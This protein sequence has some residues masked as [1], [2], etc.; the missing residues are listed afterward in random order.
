MMNIVV[1]MKQVPDL[2]QIRIRNR[3]PV[4]DG[5]Q[6][7]F[8]SLDKN[9][10]EAGVQLKK[11]MGGKVIVL[12]VGSEDLEDTVKE[13]LA[14]GGDEAVLIA[15]DEYTNLD[16]QQTAIL[17]AEGIKKI[18][19][20]GIVLFGEGSGDNYSSQVIGRV[21]ELL[22]WPQVCYV[23]EISANGNS[24]IAT[25]SLEESIEKVEV[26]MPVVVSVVAEIN[27]IPIPPVSQILK[28]GRKPKEV[29]EAMDI[30]VELPLEA[31]SIISRL[32]P[33][34]NRRGVIVNSVDELMN[35]LK[36]ENVI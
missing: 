31:I 11:A 28:A 34:N 13:A 36:S 29:L 30:E 26:E 20:V 25:R 16:S 14:A 24:I 2:Q 27:Q 19:D 10:L 18:E 5:V 35:A 21:G 7:T 9:A 3:K 33:E 8:G 15:D 22:E 6:Y 17:I 1:A 12:C 4:F 32:A 23:N